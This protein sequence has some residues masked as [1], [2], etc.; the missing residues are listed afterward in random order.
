[1]PTVMYTQDLNLNA[2]CKTGLRNSIYIYVTF[3][4]LTI[5]LH[6][7]HMQFSVANLHFL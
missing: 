3:S 5:T 6:V 7:T 2:P 4:V 1:M